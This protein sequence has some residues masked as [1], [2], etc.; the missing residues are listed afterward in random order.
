M[1]DRSAFHFPT[2]QDQT[3]RVSAFVQTK[4][5]TRKYECAAA[6][7]IF[8]HLM[9]QNRQGN[10]PQSIGV[11]LQVVMGEKTARKLRALSNTC[12]H[13]FRLYLGAFFSQDPSVLNAETFKLSLGQF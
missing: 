5:L 7:I 2:Q 12:K 6:A 13:V 8:V 9:D 11:F 10:S 3:G 4:W 1:E